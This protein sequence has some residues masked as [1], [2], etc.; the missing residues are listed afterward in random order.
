MQ[1]RGAADFLDALVA[2]GMLDREGRGYRNTAATD[3]FLDRSKPS[4]LGGILEM[5][6]AR[7]YPFWGSL[8]EALRTGL[9][10]NEA[11]HGQDPFAAIYA[12]PPRASTSVSARSARWTWS[13]KSHRPSQTTVYTS[14]P[15]TP[16]R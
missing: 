16:R 6:N 14:R 3:L 15:Q 12:D 4:Y 1:R 7:L 9:P 13:T 2:L 10:Q 11:K 5:A 8:T